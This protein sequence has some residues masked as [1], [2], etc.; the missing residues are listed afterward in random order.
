MERRI[1]VALVKLLQ[2]WYR[3]SV[4]YVRWEATYSRPYNLLAGIKQGSV[5][6]P[7]LFATC[8]YVNDMPK[9]FKHFGYYCFGL[10]LSAVMYVD[11]LKLIRRLCLSCKLC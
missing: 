2:Y 5:L 7:T 10:S 1:P 9:K 4:N 8:I 11:D 6:S 3:I